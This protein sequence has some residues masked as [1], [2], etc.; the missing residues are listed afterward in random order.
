MSIFSFLVAS[1]QHHIGKLRWRDYC[2][3]FLAYWAT[4]YLC[5]H[6][7]PVSS[8]P[9]CHMQ[10]VRNCMPASVSGTL[11]ATFVLPNAP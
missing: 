11:G 5:E 10:L 8:K 1:T 6:E 2:W 9:L 4:S 7:L 3:T